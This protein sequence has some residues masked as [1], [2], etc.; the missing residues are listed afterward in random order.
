M[1]VLTSWDRRLIHR[2]HKSERVHAECH[3]QLPW[4]TELYGW[5]PGRFFGVCWNFG[6]QIVDGWSAFDWS[7]S[8]AGRKQCELSDE[9]S[10]GSGSDRV[11]SP[12]IRLAW[13]GPGRYRSRYW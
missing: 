6:L 3:V 9:V 4:I 13:I 7:C 8:S 2:T 10:T 12:Q 1:V 11:I 5:T